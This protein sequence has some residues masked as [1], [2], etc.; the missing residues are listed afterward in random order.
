MDAL[1]NPDET[2]NLLGITTR[3]LNGL[4]RSGQLRFVRVTPHKRR[5]RN[6]DIEDFIERRLSPHRIDSTRPK[7]VPSPQKGGE[8]GNLDRAQERRREMRSWR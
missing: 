5:F 3:D 1:L 2:A 6:S 4:C 7:T 8:T